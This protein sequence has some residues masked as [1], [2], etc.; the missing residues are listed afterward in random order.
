MHLFLRDCAPVFPGLAREDINELIADYEAHFTEGSA[1]GRSEEDVSRALGEP[2]RLAREL[3]AE[4]GL[5][6][7][8]VAA[9]RRCAT[10]ADGPDNLPV[11]NDRK[12]AGRVWLTEC[13]TGNHGLRARLRI[14]RPVIWALSAIAAPVKGS[15]CSN[16]LI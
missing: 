6:A 12:S 16:R 3:R 4:A 7:F 13:L 8:F 10:D 11:N 5:G 2:G 9:R 15:F 1:A 14:D